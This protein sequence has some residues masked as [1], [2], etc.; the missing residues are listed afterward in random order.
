LRELLA[1]AAEWGVFDRVGPGHAPCFG[2]GTEATMS[3]GEQVLD[4]GSGNRGACARGG[5][6]A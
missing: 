6:R 3:G 5:L 1:G 4:V 2:F